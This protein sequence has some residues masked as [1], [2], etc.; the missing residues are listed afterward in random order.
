MHNKRIGR[1]DILKIE[2]S[3][4]QGATCVA[5]I[6]TQSSGLVLPHLLHGALNV[7]VG[8]TV[9]AVVVAAPLAAGPLARAV[10]PATTLLARMIA[11]TVT[12]TMTVSVVTLATVLAAP[13]LGKRRPNDGRRSSAMTDTEASDRDRDIRETKEERDE[14]RENGGSRDER[15][16]K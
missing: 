7:V 15:K 12:V 8:R 14:P 3:H 1:D 4:S 16:R 13:I 2:V 6:L 5:K 10:A 9:T 11:G